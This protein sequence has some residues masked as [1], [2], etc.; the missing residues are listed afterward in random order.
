MTVDLKETRYDP[1]PDTVYMYWKS[2]K[3]EEMDGN[4]GVLKEKL[5]KIC[6][7]L[8]VKHAEFYQNA[9]NIFC[10]ETHVLTNMIPIFMK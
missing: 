8:A 7:S 5:E 9:A 6:P 3:L 2:H 10:P 1:Q 4:V